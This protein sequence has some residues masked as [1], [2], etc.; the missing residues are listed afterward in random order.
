SGD[1][2]QYEHEK[3]E[4]SPPKIYPE[5]L[6]SLGTHT[7]GLVGSP[8]P[9][10]DF[11]DSVPNKLFEYIASGLPCV[12]INS[13]EAQRYVEKHKLGLGVADPK[14][15]IEALHALSNDT[16]VIKKRWEHAMEAEIPKL[17]GFYQEVLCQCTA[18]QVP[19]NSASP[20]DE[21][22]PKAEKKEESSPSTGIAR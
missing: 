16:S 9:L 4:V 8:Y 21:A 1:Y 13:P 12:V 17:T 19:Q 18:S 10:Q 20:K 3:V 11:T 15:A 2:S 5:L 6:D 22:G 14:E 7:A